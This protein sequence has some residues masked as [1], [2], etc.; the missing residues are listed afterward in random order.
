LP[1]AHVQ[2]MLH[3]TRSAAETRALGRRLALHM[4]PGD[5]LCLRG[6]LGAGKTTLIQG[7]AEGLG[8]ADP[9]TSPSFTLIHEHSGTLPLIHIDLYRLGGPDI[10]DIGLEEVIDFEAVVAVE[11]AE[12]LPAGLAR[13]ALDIDITFDEADDDTRRIHLRARSPHAARILS[14]LAEATDAGSRA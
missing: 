5:I 4:Q 10:A 3:T 1:P 6:E 2:A 7:L 13:D 12:K 9:V 11:W 8:I 14:S